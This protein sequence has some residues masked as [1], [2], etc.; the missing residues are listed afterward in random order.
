MKT[1]PAANKTIPAKITQCS[2]CA[3]KSLAG[4]LLML[5]PLTLLA[6]AGSGPTLGFNSP[7]SMSSGSAS[8]IDNPMMPKGVLKVA[9]EER[10]LLWVDLKQGKLNELERS[11]AGG[12]ELRQVIPVSI[13]KNGFGKEE[14]GDRKT[15][16][17]VY[18]LTSFL[19]DEQLIDFYGL[20]AF[21]LNYPNVIDR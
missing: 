1:G 21:P 13:G 18:R 3:R 2:D 11:D 9:P 6:Q 15:P 5:L 7:D 19:T 20:G 16:V 14:E 4:V 10:Y 8:I 12:M 17:G